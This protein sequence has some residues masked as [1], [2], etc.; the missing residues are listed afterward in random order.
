MVF[1]LN[2][3]CSILK[4]MKKGQNVLKRLILLLL[5]DEFLRKSESIPSCLR[6]PTDLKMQS[7]EFFGGQDWGMLLWGILERWVE[8]GQGKAVGPGREWEEAR[9]SLCLGNRAQMN[10]NQSPQGSSHQASICQPKNT[11][12]VSCVAWMKAF[13]HNRTQIYTFVL[14]LTKCIR[15]GFENVSCH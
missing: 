5:D 11:G 6:A 14:Y 1:V 2:F 13:V 3:F 15:F 4:K 8:G 9:T 10:I 12:S 7:S